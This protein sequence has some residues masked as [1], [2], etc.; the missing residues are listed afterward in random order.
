MKNNERNLLLPISVFAIIGIGIG[1]MI[2]L[3][4]QEPERTVADVISQKENTTAFLSAAAKADLLS[5]LDSQST[6]VTVFVPTNEAFDAF[7]GYQDVLNNEDTSDLESLLE[8]HILAGQYTPAILTSLEEAQTINEKLLAV[9]VDEDGQI[10]IGDAMVIEEGTEV[11]NSIVYV[12]DK[13]LQP[14]EVE[15]DAAAIEVTE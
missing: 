1:L 7:E 4:Q 6:A 2:V 15:E 10:M 9:S 11:G 5:G 3:G 8:D 12:V 14:T 13:V